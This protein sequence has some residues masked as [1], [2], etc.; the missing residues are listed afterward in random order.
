MNRRIKKH[1][2]LHTL[3]PYEKEKILFSNTEGIP[4]TEGYLQTQYLNQLLS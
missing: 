4:N 3:G 1:S 2:Y